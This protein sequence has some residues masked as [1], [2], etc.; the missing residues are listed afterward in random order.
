[1]NQELKQQYKL[2]IASAN[3]TQLV[4]ILY[5]MFLQY[6]KEGKEAKEKEDVKAFKDAIKHA[7][8]CV[9]ELMQS[10]N[11]DYK[12]AEELM[13]LYVYVNSQLVEADV[14]KK[15]EPLDHC[16]MVMEGLLEAYREVSK[17]DQSPP[18][19]VNSQSVYAGLTYG[20]DDLVENLNQVGENRGFLV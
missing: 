10:L 17:K 7:R 15:T 16:V 9:K 8:G 4:V 13:Q 6:V 20:R 14:H 18:V 1:M 2:R 19:M 12:P 3:K 5:E 11:F